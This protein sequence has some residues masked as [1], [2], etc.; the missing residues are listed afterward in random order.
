MHH[1]KFL[2][3]CR[4]EITEQIYKRLFS[5]RGEIIETDLSA[6]QAGKGKIYFDIVVEDTT[7]TIELSVS[8][9]DERETITINNEL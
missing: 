5:K 8:I 6:M 3:D 9:I 4:Y 1:L 7:L 2:Q